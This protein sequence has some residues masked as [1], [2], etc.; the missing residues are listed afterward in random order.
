MSTTQTRVVALYT[1]P[2]MLY[3]VCKVS[4]KFS[5]IIE[6]TPPRGLLIDFS[7]AR[8][9]DLSSL[10]AETSAVG[11][12]PVLV[13]A[14]STRWIA[15]CAVAHLRRR[16]RV[17]PLE[18]GQ[19]REKEFLAPLPIEYLSEGEVATD[20]GL[21]K[22]LID[23]GIYTFGALADISLKELT[24]QFG[25]DRGPLLHRLARG[26][27]PRRVQALYPA[28]QV[29]ATFCVAPD[30]SGILNAQAVDQVLLH[31]STELAATLNHQGMAARQVRLVIA[32]RKSVFNPSCFLRQP[33]SQRD[34]LLGA[35]RRLWSSV[36][37]ADPVL[38]LRLCG[39]NLEYPHLEQAAIFAGDANGGEELTT[40]V[41]L[42]RKRFGERALQKASQLPL[43]RRE[44]I[45]SMWERE[46]L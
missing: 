36:F 8:D 19:G 3:Q 1:D 14:A 33:I 18:I 29:V 43:S 22:R 35:A 42:V 16:G 5:P 17:T 21:I 24:S 23:L 40:V 30:C 10:Q 13:G 28:R 39:E 34:A 38:K 25:T 37:V 27:D 46:Q 6:P 7:G 32:G 12:S 41:N 15:R 4:M 31:L 9:A 2:E 11:P 44:L 45:R 20:E 26:I